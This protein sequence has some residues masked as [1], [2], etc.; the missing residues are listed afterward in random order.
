[1][2]MQVILIEEVFHNKDN[3]WKYLKNNNN[4]KNCVLLSSLNSIAQETNKFEKLKISVYR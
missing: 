3:E 1:M 4:N 2:L